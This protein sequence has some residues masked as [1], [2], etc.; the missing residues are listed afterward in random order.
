MLDAGL[1]F[2]QD[3]LSAKL[4]PMSACQETML[5]EYLSAV[6]HKRRECQSLLAKLAAD[7]QGA[8]EKRILELKSLERDL[9]RRFE[10]LES[11]IEDA[12]KAVK[13]RIAMIEDLEYD[14]KYKQAR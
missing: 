11:G 4:A 12:S 13:K 6:A 8:K 2:H 1:S 9:L 10:D 14:I 5:T 7:S 3:P